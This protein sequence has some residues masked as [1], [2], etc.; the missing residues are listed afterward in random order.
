MAGYIGRW[1]MALS[2]H[3]FK[4]HRITG[5]DPAKPLFYTHLI[6]LPTSLSHFDADV[7]KS[8]VIGNC[9]K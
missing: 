1:I 7:S 5:L 2:T 8:Y 3:S 4:L 9:Q 6:M